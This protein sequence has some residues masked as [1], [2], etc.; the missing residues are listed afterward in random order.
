M[1]VK[2]VLRDHF[3]PVFLNRV[4][5]TIVFHRLSRDNLREIVEIQ[6]RHLRQRLTDRGMTLTL[7][8]AAKDKLAADGYDPVYGARPLKRLIQQEIEN[9]LAKRILT[10]DFVEGASVTIDVTGEAFHFAA[11]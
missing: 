5:E 2:E 3:R 10:G 7:T 4:D 6:V 9:P 1:A 8:D 11:G